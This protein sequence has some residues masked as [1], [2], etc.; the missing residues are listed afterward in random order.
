MNKVTLITHESDFT[1]FNS[2][3]LTPLFNKYFDLTTYDGISKYDPKSSVV[4]IGCFNQSNFWYQPL[5]DA[6]IKVVVDNLWERDK[7][8]KF[9]NVLTLLNQNWMWYNDALWWKSLNYDT[10]IPNKKYTHTAFMPMRLEKPHRTQLISKLAPYL[11]DMIYSYVAKNIFLPNDIDIDAGIFQR[12]FNPEWYDNTYYSIV[13]ETLIDTGSIL[14]SEK[15]FK[16]IAFRHPFMI[17]GQ[18]NILS[19]IKKL[20]FETFENLFDE[21][22]DT[23]YNYYARLSLI[24]NN[25]KNFQRTPYNN[26]TLEKLEH[27][28]NLFF[29]IAKINKCIIQEVIFPVLDYVT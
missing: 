27:N 19:Y 6:G 21:S 29:D 28:H 24:E 7:V 10:Y 5:V 23:E 20:G 12:Y 25:V 8:N 17:A 2:Y 22:Y 11:S 9:T 4:V 14:V 1:S 15:T 18:Q 13:S 3:Y 16:P 26:I